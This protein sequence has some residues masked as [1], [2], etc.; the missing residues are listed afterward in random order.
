MSMEMMV[1]AEGR[2]DMASSMSGG[3][4]PGGVRTR[5]LTAAQRRAVAFAQQQ[6]L[7]AR[8][9]RKSKDGLCPAVRHT[10]RQ[11]RADSGGVGLVAYERGAVESPHNGMSLRGAI[12]CVLRDLRT[13]EHKTLREVS[14]KAGV[15]LGYL[16]EVERGQKEASS[17][18]LVSIA[19]ALGLSA[20]QMLRAVAD[21]LDSCGI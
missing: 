3:V 10:W 13:R 4:R 7:K 18:L 5:D 20:A 15:S 6:V 1:R 17:D 21:Y 16:S 9:V 2:K 19:R 12:G 11:E 8:A 14:E